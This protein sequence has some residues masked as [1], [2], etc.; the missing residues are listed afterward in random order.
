MWVSE[1]F[2]EDV[3]VIV[4]EIVLKNFYVIE[5]SKCMF[6]NVGDWDVVEVLMLEFVE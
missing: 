3:F 5:V 1:M 4:K 2:F 6:N